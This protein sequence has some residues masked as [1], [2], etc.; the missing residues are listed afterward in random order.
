[1]K[2]HPRGSSTAKTRREA[3]AE[4]GLRGSGTLRHLLV[5]LS[6]GDGE[7]Q[8]G[9]DG[10]NPAARA[11]SAPLFSIQASASLGGIAG[12]LSAL[13]AGDGRGLT[14]TRGMRSAERVKPMLGCEEVKTRNDST[15]GLYLLG[16]HVGE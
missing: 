2:R 6:C 5:A 3:G 15:S 16:T 10:P 4:G 1:L 8:I 13:A 9:R 7:R 14:R 11:N 12:V